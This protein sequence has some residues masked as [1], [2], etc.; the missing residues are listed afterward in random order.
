[1]ADAATSEVLASVLIAV[2]SA[3]L[4]K[5]LTERDDPDRIVFLTNILLLPVALL[6][7]LFVW[8][9]PSADVLPALVG[10]GA[11]AVAGHACVVRGYA[12]TEASLAM[13]FEF[14]KL[15]FAVGI[16]RCSQRNLSKASQVRNV[17]S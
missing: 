5:Q 14:S 2:V 6:P 7:A 4:V 12:L 17:P 1:M 11:C 3:V 9:W 8:R 10:M 15:P 16:A 13:T